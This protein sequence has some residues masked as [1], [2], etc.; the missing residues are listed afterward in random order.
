M[1]GIA[2]NQSGRLSHIN[3][4]PDQ[5]L[6]WRNFSQAIVLG[7]TATGGSFRWLDESVAWPSAAATGSSAA[8]STDLHQECRLI[9]ID[10]LVGDA[11]GLIKNPSPL[12]AATPRISKSFDDNVHHCCYAWNRLI[13]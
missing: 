7:S 11:T 3:W 6:C 2:E 4:P 12:H 5:R 10:M 9:P 8:S 1:A 13:G